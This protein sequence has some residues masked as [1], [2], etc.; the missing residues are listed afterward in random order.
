V[1]KIVVILLLIVLLSTIAH[2][3]HPVIRPVPNGS[4]GIGVG[5]ANEKSPIFALLC[6]LLLPGG[7]Q[8]YTENNLKGVLFFAAQTCM[9]SVILYEH[10]KAENSW[11]RYKRTGDPAYYED[12]SHYKEK[13]DDHLW[14]GGLI[15][16]LSCADAYIDAHF[17]R[18]N[19]EMS[20]KIVILE[21]RF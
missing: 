20:L 8:F 7:G 10:Q 11:L 9:L 19:A 2:A 3:Q 16:G 1:K 12:Y 17:Y 18:F 14:W 6:S 15:W 5:S 21:I 4:V 13:R